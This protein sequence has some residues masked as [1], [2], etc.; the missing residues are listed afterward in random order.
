[1]ELLG[2][3]TATAF[4]RDRGEQQQERETLRPGFRSAAP[5]KQRSRHANS[6]RAITSRLNVRIELHT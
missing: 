4:V 2:V 6:W 5:D 3:I 1:M